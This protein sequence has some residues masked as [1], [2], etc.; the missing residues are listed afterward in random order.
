MSIP[1][2]GQ[3]WTECD[4]EQSDLMGTVLRRINLDDL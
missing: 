3:E 1:E 2:G 4:L